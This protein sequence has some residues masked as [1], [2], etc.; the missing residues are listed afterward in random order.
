MLL[1]QFQ[2]NENRVVC[3]NSGFRLSWSIIFLAN[4]SRFSCARYIVTCL[5][6]TAKIMSEFKSHNPTDLPVFCP[7]EGEWLLLAA[8][9]CQN[10]A[11]T[12][13]SPHHSTAGIAEHQH[14]Q[15]S[16]C[17]PATPWWPQLESQELVI[18]LCIADHF[19]D[20]DVD[21]CC[22]AVQPVPLL[23]CLPEQA[24]FFQLC[25]QSQLLCKT[26]LYKNINTYVTYTCFTYT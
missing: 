22:A 7:H 21:R 16:D 2:S 15:L 9:R 8:D 18:L 5:P 3:I 1:S 19:L 14:S 6:N 17:A 26:V 4:I 13:Q 20:L 10:T 12:H 24:L 11:E 25:W 23:A